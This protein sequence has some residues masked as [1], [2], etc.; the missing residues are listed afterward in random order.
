MLCEEVIR[1]DWEGAKEEGEGG[2]NRRN[3]KGS[4]KSADERYED[5]RGR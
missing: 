1:R 2:R 4:E 5:E 3:R